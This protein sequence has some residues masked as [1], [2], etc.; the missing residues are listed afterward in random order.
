M[1]MSS[2]GIVSDEAGHFTEGVCIV[3]STYD[4]GCSNSDQGLGRLTD[5]F[6]DVESARALWSG[7]EAVVAGHAIVRMKEAGSTRAYSYA[8][9]DNWIVHIEGGMNEAVFVR[10]SNHGGPDDAG[11]ILAGRV[12]AGACVPSPGGGI[13]VDAGR[14]L[15]H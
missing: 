6:F 7:N 1:W 4:G 5:S 11:G 13:H 8:I 14:R 3:G 2:H 15:K 10:A 9:A 12:C